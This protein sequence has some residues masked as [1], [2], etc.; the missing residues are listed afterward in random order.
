MLLQ[1]PS[2]SILYTQMSSLGRFLELKQRCRLAS[3][4]VLHPFSSLCL[5]SGDS[6]KAERWGGR[7]VF[8]LPSRWLVPAPDS[9]P[10]GTSAP[11]RTGGAPAGGEGQGRLPQL[12]LPGRGERGWRPPATVCFTSF[13][14]GPVCSPADVDSFPSCRCSASSLPLP[15]CEGL[16]KSAAAAAADDPKVR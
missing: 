14:R 5:G 13:P 9:F 12:G 7:E 16:L 6:G 15:R 2:V 3:M 8:V 4:V 1:L 10:A 11:L